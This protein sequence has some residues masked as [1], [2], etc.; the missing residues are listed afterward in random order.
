[1]GPRPEDSGRIKP[2]PAVCT[3]IGLRSRFNGATARRPRTNKGIRAEQPGS[4]P[5]GA[6]MGPQS[7]DRGERGIHRADWV[8]LRA[9]M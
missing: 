9:S 2:H 3:T 5:R 4:A 8:E 1:M 7:E 6:S